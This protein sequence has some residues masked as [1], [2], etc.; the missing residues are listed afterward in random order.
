M[1]QNGGQGRARAS[2]KFFVE[3]VT[4]TAGIDHAQSKR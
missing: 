4:N 1:I 2:Q 3:P